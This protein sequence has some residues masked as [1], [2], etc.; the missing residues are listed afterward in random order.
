[1]F[2]DPAIL[3]L[4]IYLNNQQYALLFK[5]T[6][7]MLGFFLFCGT[8]LRAYTLSHSTSPFFMGFS[9]IGSCK[10]FAQTGFK[11]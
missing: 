6:F 3:F 1:M 9:E 2:S 7:I 4:G 11:P 5:N 8:E 10:L